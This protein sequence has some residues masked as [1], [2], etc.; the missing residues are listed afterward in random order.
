MCK[1]KESM[2]TYSQTDTIIIIAEKVAAVHAG[3]VAMGDNEMATYEM[4][5]EFTMKRSTRQ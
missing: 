5:P 4:R 2:V 3:D 1:L